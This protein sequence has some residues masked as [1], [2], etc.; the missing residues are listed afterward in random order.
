MSHTRV[1]K[2]IG[3]ETHSRGLHIVA[4]F[5]GAKGLLVLIVG[6]EL[7]TLINKDAHVAALRLVEQL[8]F[9]P[10]SHYPRIFL[11]L[12]EH[13]SDAKLQGMAIA[14]AIY[15]VVRLVEA[16]GLWLR[17]TWAEWFGAITGG[18]FIPLAIYKI[19]QHVTWH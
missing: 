3:S 16:A 2:Q 8:H 10:S 11:D 14:A 15:S 13:V 17:K 19:A 6:F 7:L 4:F 12:T 5:E 18:M 1:R 9:N